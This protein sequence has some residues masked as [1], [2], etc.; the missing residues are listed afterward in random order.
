M[1]TLPFNPV[2]ASQEMRNGRVPYPVD[3]SSQCL[4]L[5][6]SLLADKPGVPETLD[7]HRLRGSFPPVHS[8]RRLSLSQRGRIE[9]RDYLSG[10]SRE[11]TKSLAEHC[12]VLREL[13]DPKL[14]G[15]QFRAARKTRLGSDHAVDRSDRDRK[16]TRLNSSHSS[17][18]YAVFS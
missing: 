6:F 15:L 9:V 17:I 5:H 10:V 11:P 1:E 13:G 12:R 7:A 4:L 14:G 8:Q 3:H 16:S 18:S 2:P